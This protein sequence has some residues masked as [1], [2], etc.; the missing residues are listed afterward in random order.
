MESKMFC[1]QCQETA[2]GKGCMVK[3]VCGKTAEVAKLQ[4]KLIYA[5]K[6]LSASKV[7]NV[8]QTII[9][10][11]FCTITNAN[12]DPKILSDRI[13]QTLKLIPEQIEIPEN[14]GVL[15]KTR[16]FEVCAS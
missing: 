9:L 14:V 15:A 4:D 3:G 12:F 10:N 6:K 5:T 1:Y 7:S 2:N 16:I 8:D 13:D 11:L